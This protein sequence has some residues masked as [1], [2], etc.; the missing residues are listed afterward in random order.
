MFVVTG[1]GSG[2]GRALAEA[3]AR[4]GKKVLIVGRRQDA[5]VTSA[6][7]SPLLS[8]VC[9]DVSEKEGRRAIANALHEVKTIEGLV[10][11]AGRIDPI[12][13][14]SEIREEQWQA[15]MATNVEA[16]LFLSQLLLPKLIDGRVL[17]IGSGA[18]YFPVKAW[19]AYCVSKA[20]LAML[21]QCWQIE[22]EQVAFASVK[23][24]IIDTA[25]QTQIRQSGVMDEE[26]HAFFQRLKTENRLLTPSV[27]ALFLSWL[28]L[29]VDRLT[30]RTHDEWDIYD[31]SHHSQ[32]LSPP[33]EVPLWD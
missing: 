32:W 6:A 5:L 29:D 22:M 12:M 33:Y 14:I 30:Y 3:L 10:H 15:I 18:A 8:Y 19:S 20:A 1:G 28:L 7:F 31:S 4:R 13:P 17:H 26:K 11:N 24:G 9:A 23:P 16:P 21:T 27:V 25:M 2:I